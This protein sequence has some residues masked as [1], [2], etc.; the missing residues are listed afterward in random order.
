M[1]IKIYRP[2]FNYFYPL[3][4]ALLNSK[5]IIVLQEVYGQ[6]TALFEEALVG[7]SKLRR[8]R[9]GDASNAFTGMVKKQ[10]LGCVIAHP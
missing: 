5:D 6:L 8:F 10:A 7:L 3:C 1:K 4:K 9:S 2:F